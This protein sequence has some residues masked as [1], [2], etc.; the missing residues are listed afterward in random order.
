MILVAGATGV[1]GSEIVRRLLARGEKV[2]AMV[3]VTSAPEKV[4]RLKKAGTEIVRA[5]LKDPQTLLAACEGVSGVI[6]TVTTILTAQAGDSFDATDRDGT[7]NLIDA[8]KQKGVRKFVFVSF[9]TT[10]TPENPL[11]NAKRDVEDHLKKSGLDYTI[12]QPSLFFESWLGPMLF[13]DPQAGTAKVYG[14]GTDKIRYVAVAD[15]AQFAVE[16]LSNPAARNA[17]ISFG[18]PDEISQRE[19]VRIFEEAYGKSFSV[20]EVPEVVLEAQWRAA[21]NPFD[22]TFA[23]LML[24][25]ARGFESGPQPPLDKFPIQMTSPREYV[26]RMAKAS[27]RTVDGEQRQAPRPEPPAD[28][29]QAE[30]R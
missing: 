9:D 5:D 12:L 27:E 14:K 10:K 3:R 29:G 28:A 8:A 30:L 25:V 23:G 7:K 11:S 2:R 1:L 21:E 22:K 16:S 13:A 24:G 26:R 18:G 17:T 4:E 20:V 6:S 19:A 15:V